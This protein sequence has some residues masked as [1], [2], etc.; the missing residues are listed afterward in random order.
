MIPLF[1][2]PYSWENDNYKS[3]WNDLMEV[4]E[5]GLEDRHFLG[6]VVTK[7]LDATP[8]G[9]S[10]FL[11]ID[12]QQRLTTLTL[13]LAALR[14][15]AKATDPQLADK[16]HRL[17]LTNEF[18]SDNHKYKVLPTQSD[19]EAYHSIIEGGSSNG[20][21][22]RAREAY[23]Y[24]LD[25]IAESDADGERLDLRRLE[26]VIVTGLELVSITLEDTDNEYRIF[27]SLNG[28]GTPLTQSD[29]LR[30]YFFMRMP[31]ARHEE[32]YDNVWL[33][34]QDSLGGALEDFF[35]YQYMST[36]QFVREADV[37]QAWKK[38]LDPLDPEELIERLKDLAR[39]AQF[40]KRFM[41][42]RTEPDAKIARGFARLNR[43]GGQTFYPFL[44]N[45]YRRYNEGTMSADQYA[46]I[47]RL[48]ESFLVRRFFA[49]IRTTQL[50]RLFMRLAQQLP[51]DRDIVEATKTAL[52]EPGRRWPRDEQFRERIL[53]FPLYTEGRYEQRRLIL[54]TLEESYGSK[55]S[56]DPNK[57][58]IEH[59]MPQ[60]LTEEW[61]EALGEYAAEIHA[62][63]VHLLGNL[64]LTGYN[65]EL[66]NS[67][68]PVKREKLVQSNV[69]MNK[70]IARETEWT[71]AQI[72]ERGRRL[73]ERALEIWPGPT[74]T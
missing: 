23:G 1:Q 15:T 27:E 13:L 29:L 70:E 72:A 7:S 8:E 60:T 53:Q 47:L 54:E 14:D 38:R 58:N 42:P 33:P 37:Y 10:P 61:K 17:Y 26:Q 25:R 41:V 21:Q 19:R 63:M 52:S 36:G 30:N 12:G 22:P 20:A 50:N 31:A 39:N 49:G 2:R 57:L 56:V 35:R 45:M 68:F 9:V 32:M 34:M 74:I 64:T 28:T 51:K 71:P 24:F 65:P 6:S 46:E 44:L 4:Y 16:I 66:S 69:E 62:E 48:I 40:Y 3:L 67:P 73:A 55:E 43:W 59:V 5:A 18:A 11:V